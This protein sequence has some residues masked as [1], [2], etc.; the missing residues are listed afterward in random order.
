MLTVSLAL[1]LECVILKGLSQYSPY[2]KYL[3]FILVATL[4]LVMG[5]RYNVG[6]DYGAYV[7][8]YDNKNSVN[9]YAL[10][11][12][13]IWICNGM[14]YIGFKSRA[15]FF[16]T[17]MLI[18]T[19]YYMG[20]KKLSPEIYMSL[21]IFIGCGFYYE[22]SNII[23]QFC[24]QAVLFAATVPLLRGEWKK[25]AVC[26]VCAM[27]LHVSAI[28]GVILMLISRHNYSIWL[29]CGV[30]AVSVVSGGTVSRLIETNVLV[31]TASSYTS[32]SFSA[33][34]SSGLLKYVYNLIGIIFLALYPRL[35]R[36]NPRAVFFLNIVVIGICLYN[37]FYTF[38]VMRR[39][40]MYCLPYMTILLPMTG[41]LFKRGSKVLYISTVVLVLMT[42]MFKQ[43][44]N[45]QY[46][47][48]LNFF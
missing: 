7:D 15:F 26:A 35:R 14:S 27:M 47:F 16:L 10:E 33:G 5:L 23:R 8:I 9:R 25:F 6:V 43:L 34:V 1:I 13:W 32:E 48:D 37:I 21:I 40:A 18:M 2:R 20:M 29:M 3:P 44:A 45:T 42:F 39:M 24:A 19:G 46:K 22:S 12:T 28:V 4:I 41:K 31:L 11:P 17:S 36:V 38:M 30:F